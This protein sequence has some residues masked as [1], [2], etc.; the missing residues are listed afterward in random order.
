[1]SCQVL[2]DSIHTRAGWTEPYLLFVADTPVGY[3]SIAVGGP[4]TGKPTVFEFYVLPQ[5]RSRVFDL[6]CTL[7]AASGAT[8]IETQ[9][10]APLLTVMLHTFAENV[11]SESI[12]F[13]DKLTTAHRPQGALF[14]HITTDDSAQILAQKLDT[15][16]DWVVEVEGTIAA[17]GGILFHYNRPY[18]D[19]YMQVA[20]PFRKRGLGAYLVQELKRVCYEQGSVPA[21]RCN[22]T[23]IA[24]RKTLQKAGFVPCGHVLVGLLSPSA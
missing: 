9:S 2:K 13:H 19:I 16:T 6:F 15:G 4:W 5:Y 24:S 11:V 17:T 12:L 23:N 7:L 22:P 10:N 20:E 8:M 1:M 18:G 3:G 14:R 21:A